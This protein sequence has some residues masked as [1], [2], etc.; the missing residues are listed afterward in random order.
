MN[1][2]FCLYLKFVN[3]TLK[4]ITIAGC[5]YICGYVCIPY[6]LVNFGMCVCMAGDETGTK[7]PSCDVEMPQHDYD[8]VAMDKGGSLNKNVALKITPPPASEPEEV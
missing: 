3:F 1:F 8:E 7:V 6:M 2:H 5:M 4:I